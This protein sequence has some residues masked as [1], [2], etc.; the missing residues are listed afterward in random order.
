MTILKKG[1]T[2]LDS[3]EPITESEIRGFL[4]KISYPFVPDFKNALPPSP[5]SN[6]WRM[7]IVNKQDNS[8]FDMLIN[9]THWNLAIVTKEST[10]MNLEYLTFPWELYEQIRSVRGPELPM[11][12]QTLERSFGKEELNELSKSE[13][14]QLKYW[15]SRTIGDVIFNGFD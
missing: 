2:G 8:E 12:P 14:D 9:S 5:S 15:K 11:N 10:W 1:I 6:F 13:L 3:V 7:P 4:E